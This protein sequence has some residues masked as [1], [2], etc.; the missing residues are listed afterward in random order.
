ME[1]RSIIQIRKLGVEEVRWEA[2]HSFWDVGMT[3]DAE[4]YL[5]RTENQDM[6]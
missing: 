3:S 5:D 1:Y 2:T 4:N 6:D